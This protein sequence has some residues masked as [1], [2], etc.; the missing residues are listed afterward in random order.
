MESA[1]RVGYQRN[2]GGVIQVLGQIF[3]KME[4]LHRVA[5]VTE[6]RCAV[7]PEDL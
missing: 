3:L 4:D 7:L 1:Y 5:T 2:I 6:E